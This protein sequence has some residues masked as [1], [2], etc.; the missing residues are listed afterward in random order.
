MQ[1]IELVYIL[2]H[3]CFHLEKEYKLM[4]NLYLDNKYQIVLLKLINFQ[5]KIIYHYLI[6]SL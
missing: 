1:D 3:I 2:H 5:L 4:D 6:F